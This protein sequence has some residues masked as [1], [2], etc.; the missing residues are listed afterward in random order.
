MSTTQQN[1]RREPAEGRELLEKL[2]IWQIRLKVEAF[3]EKYARTRYQRSRCL[4]HLSSF[5][6]SALCFGHLHIL[7]SQNR[8]ALLRFASNAIFC[9]EIET[10]LHVCTRV[11][12]K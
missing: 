3:I 1:L 7:E 9:M 10:K 11:F 2:F 6:H 5:L 4:T 12:V 8:G